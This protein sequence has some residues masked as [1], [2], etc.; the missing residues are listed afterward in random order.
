MK[1]LLMLVMGLMILTQMAPSAP[2][3]AT[4]DYEKYGKIAITVV[5]ADYPGD[6]VTD[7][8]YKGRKKLGNKQV[9]D[10]FVFIVVENGKEFNVIVTVQHDLENKKLLSLKVME[11]KR[12]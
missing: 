4:P 5:Q 7:Y 9:E 8:Q 12:K 6:D 10:D 3:A 11:Q 1:K 2:L